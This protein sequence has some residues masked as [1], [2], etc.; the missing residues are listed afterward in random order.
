MPLQPAQRDR[1]V[2]TAGAVTGVGAGAE[3]RDWGPVR[4]EDELRALEGVEFF[5]RAVGPRDLGGGDEH[6]FRR[7]N[8]LMKSGFTSL[9]LGFFYRY[10][11]YAN[12]KFSENFVVKL[13]SSFLF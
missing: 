7:I 13:S 4:V 9:G 2:E 8:N 11:N 6:V 3:Q 12:E 1:D 5:L 10:G